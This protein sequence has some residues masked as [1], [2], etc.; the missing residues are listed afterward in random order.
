[1]K[2]EHEEKEY[3]S[4]V[5]KLVKFFKNSRD[6]WK[7]K[8]QELK[9]KFKRQ[10]NRIRFLEKSK[11]NLKKRVKELETEVLKIKK[12]KEEREDE[13][14][15]LKK[16][17]T[18]CSKGVES[19]EIVPRH[20]HY[21][22]GHMM[23]FSSLVLSCGTSFRS[24]SQVMELF[25]SFFQVPYCSPH[26][27]SGFLWV[28]RLGYYKLM[29]PKERA[30]DWVWIVDHTVQIGQEKC[31][32]ILGLRLSSLP[33]PFRS[34]R[35]EDVEPIA[36]YPVKKSTGEIVYEQL[37]ETIE[38]TGVPREIVGDQGSDLACG[39]KKFCQKHKETCYINDIKHKTALLLKKELSPDEAWQEFCKLA[40][41]SKNKVQQ[42]SLS[43]LAPPG[44][45]SKARYMN[46]EDL[47]NWAD[48]MLK[49]LDTK[50]TANSQEIAEKFS[51]LLK[52]RC[53]IEEWKE[54]LS[55]VTVTESFV[56][57]E[58][59]YHNSHKKLKNKLDSITVER[60]RA[61]RIKGEVVDY[62]LQEESKVKK[63]EVL[64]GSSEVIES[65]F[66]KFKQLEKMQS[67]SGFTVLLL[68]IAAMVSKTTVDIIQKA[69]ETV[70]TKKIFDWCKEKLG[71]SVQ[72]KRR[73]AFS[74][75]VIP[76]Q[77]QDQVMEAA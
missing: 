77:K 18:V 11:E 28:M 37:E 16:K 48:N 5:R 72:S 22:V 19:F 67:T 30:D 53:D 71:K 69:M 35:H 59:I 40:S 2:E 1:M 51:W 55:V 6:N 9:K 32:V 68:S 41:Q 43:H 10:S 17:E 47:I 7:G 54:I 12:M 60:E 74:S 44:Q 52:F 66:G 23:L 14:E 50:R 20:H 56:R 45:K 27:Y 57:K 36:L 39:I 33:C 4:P 3:K 26:W 15:A 38:K 13:L 76:E 42:T 34:V 64:L 8:Y 70:P 58:G 25:L 65:V 46:L 62:V 73:E 24:A 21:S 61:K 63:G 31:F 49:I 29:E 75:A